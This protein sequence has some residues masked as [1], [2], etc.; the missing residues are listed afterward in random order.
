MLALHCVSRSTPGLIFADRVE[1]L[2]S[3][4]PIMQSDWVFDDIHVYNNLLGY[5]N[6]VF[7]IQKLLDSQNYV[8]HS[9][10]SFLTLRLNSPI[11]FQSA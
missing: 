11:I 7:A 5:L 4:F 2:Y 10:A 6:H 3:L 1:L 9:S 8:S